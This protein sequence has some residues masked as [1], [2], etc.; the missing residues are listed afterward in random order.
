MVGLYP[1]LPGPRL[2]YDRDGTALVK[3]DGSNANPIM[4][5][6]SNLIT[7]NNESGDY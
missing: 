6:N 5:A 7:M 2:A 4:L 1:D 3:L